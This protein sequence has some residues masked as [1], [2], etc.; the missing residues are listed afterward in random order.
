MTSA[1]VELRPQRRADVEAVDVDGELVLWDPVG[2]TVHRLDPVGSLLWPFLDGTATIA[3]LASD[4]ANVWSV[5][6]EAAAGA[7]TALVGQLGSAH[8]LEDGSPRH[9]RPRPIHL[10]DPPSP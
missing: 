6:Y 1:E 8:L 4:A 3:E 5:P 9:V 10:V 2:R 7:I